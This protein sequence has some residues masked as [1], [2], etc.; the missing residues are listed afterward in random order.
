[1]EGEIF[2]LSGAVNQA[3]IEAGFGLMITPMMG[4]LAPLESVTW[5][6][7][8]GCFSQPQRHSDKHYLDW[9]DQRPRE[10]NL[11]A[12]APDV[13]ADAEATW[14]RSRP[15]LWQIRELGYQ[16]A[17][18]AQDG[19]EHMPIRWDSFDALFIGGST[20]WK[21]GPVCFELGREAKRQGKWLHWGRVNSLKRLRMA[22][23]AHA[24]SADGTFIKYGPDRLLPKMQQW[25][26]E[27]TAQGILGI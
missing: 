21:L 11:F 18:V 14:L 7:D 13:V 8:T 9:L 16:A 2:Y 1:M 25:V 27:V 26:R 3:V 19:I 23:L 20:K 17:L 12:T 4:N 10:T 6:A 5:A 22:Y 15:M 24:D